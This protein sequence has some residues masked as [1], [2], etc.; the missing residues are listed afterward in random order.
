MCRLESTLVRNPINKQSVLWKVRGF[1]PWLML[2]FGPFSKE[3]WHKPWRADGFDL[4]ALPKMSKLRGKGAWFGGHEGWLKIPTD[5]R[6]WYR[7]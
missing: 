4:E 2:V 3:W 6:I 7:H 1:L 5:P